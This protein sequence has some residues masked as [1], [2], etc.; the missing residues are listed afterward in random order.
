MTIIDILKL[1]G[2]TQPFGNIFLLGNHIESIMFYIRNCSD[3]YGIAQI[4]MDFSREYLLVAIVTP[5][6][7]PSSHGRVFA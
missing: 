5:V 3:D 2:I 4:I 1:S 7:R 6:T